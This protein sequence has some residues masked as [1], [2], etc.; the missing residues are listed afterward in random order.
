MVL[1]CSRM[2]DSIRQISVFTMNASK[3]Y[4]FVG[5]QKLSRISKQQVAFESPARTIIF[6]CLV[7]LKL[8]ETVVLSHAFNFLEN[9][10]EDVF[11]VGMHDCHKRRNSAKRTPELAYDEPFEQDG[12]CKVI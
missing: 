2:M 8:R 9:G 5:S 3:F 11:F 6:V 7:N 12:V 10:A 1:L 4:Y